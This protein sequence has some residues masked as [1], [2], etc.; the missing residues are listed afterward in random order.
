MYLFCHLRMQ[1]LRR[2]KRRYA[3]LYATCLRLNRNRGISECDS[4]ESAI[5]LS[6]YLL[7]T[8]FTDTQGI[9]IFTLFSNSL[10]ANNFVCIGNSHRC[11]TYTRGQRG[12]GAEG[13]FRKRKYLR[14]K[15]VCF[16]N[17]KNPSSHWQA[18][19]R[20]SLFATFI[21]HCSVM[22]QSFPRSWAAKR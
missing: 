21:E 8:P 12:E 5:Y 14:D 2:P 10:I 7:G 20:H 16:R 3:I 9:A 15:H 22:T 4:P 6:F 11:R 19:P 1:S 13:E 17:G 18:P